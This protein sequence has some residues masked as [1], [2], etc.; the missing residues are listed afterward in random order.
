MICN[1]KLGDSYR[2]GRPHP[3]TNAE[4]VK[5]ISSQIEGEVKIRCANDQVQ[6]L[7]SAPLFSSPIT[8]ESLSQQLNEIIHSQTAIRTSFQL[9]SAHRKTSH[10]PRNPPISSHSEERIHE[11][12]FSV[13]EE[14]R[15]A[16]FSDQRNC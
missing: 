12:R 10:P 11:Q 14:G 4:G 9:F 13:K 16:L 8:T 3:T 6:P 2:D 15:F 1:F 5:N 7:H